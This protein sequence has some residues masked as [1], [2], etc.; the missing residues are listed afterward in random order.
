MWY[1]PSGIESHK[2]VTV[3]PS[4]LP[5]AGYGLFAE[6]EF[7]VGDTVS[8]YFGNVNTKVYCEIVYTR[9][10]ESQYKLEAVLPPSKEYMVIPGGEETIQLD[11]EGGGLPDNKLMYLGGHMMKDPK[12]TIPKDDKDTNALN[13]RIAHNL[14]LFAEK[15]INIGNEIYGDYQYL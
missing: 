15:P 1:K 14:A 9:F 6:R 2:W 13:V 3:K 10:S 7:Q 5:N 12:L 8:I 4:F 11:V